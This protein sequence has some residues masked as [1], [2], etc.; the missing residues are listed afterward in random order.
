MGKKIGILVVVLLV[1]VIGAIALFFINSQS[2]SLDYTI[3]QV[4]S[5]NYFKLYI[6]EKYGVIDTK[7]NTIIE[8]K[9]DSIDIPNPS[10]AVFIVS[11]NY[12]SQKGEYETQVIN[13]K[14]EKI[15]TQYKKIIPIQLKDANAQIPYEKSVLMYQENNKYGI[16]DF[17]GK[18]IT[19]AIYDSIESLLYKEGCLIV[20]DGEKYGVINI[21]GRKMVE[22][23][24]DSINA[25]GYYDEDT[26]Y[27]KAGFIVG[28]R[29]EEGY[30]YGYISSK[31]EKILDVEYNQINR[32]TEISDNDVYLYVTK[33][34]QVG[35]YQDKNQIIK[36]SYEQ[37]EYDKNNKIFVIKK[38]GKYGVVNI[39][40]EEILPIEYNYIMISGDKINAEKDNEKLI[41]DV[42][43]NEQ[44]VKNITL[45]ATENKK[46]FIVIDENGKFGVAD[47][48][49]IN[50][51]E[52]KYQYMEYAFG[53]YFI[54]KENNKTG[55]V[56]INGKTKIEF[57]YDVIQKI[58]NTNILQAVISSENISRIFNEKLELMISDKNMLITNEGEYIK[59]LS[60]NNREYLDK[61][62]NRISSGEIFKDSNL[63]AYSEN[64]KWG[65]K[66][67][68][69]ITKIVAKYEMVTEFNEYG[70]AG[71]YKDEKWGVIGEEGNIILEPTYVVEFEE[72]EFI[73]KY[74][75]LNFGYGFSYYTD[76]VQ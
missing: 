6:N 59:V 21:L 30:R 53:N 37:V 7:G 38:D 22:I 33:N 24:F 11:S 58:K 25:D 64:G 54:A 76:K 74:I 43:G 63:L 29:K 9:Y 41:F 40:N 75:R 13:D 51:L 50:I 60:G 73:N 5:Y 69:G 56:D 23:E 52:N 8:P 19:E 71:I 32:I 70:Y 57:D 12:D 72:P 45:I 34:G 16:I 27:K 67:R 49:G 26:G 35:V 31:S 66:D 36:N 10:K 39:S 42:N 18:K 14:N 20:K 3:E 65:F 68:S 4:T 55:I 1:I 28:L 15:L 17:S 2:D 47:K 61:N 46:Y 62:G 44:K 48:E